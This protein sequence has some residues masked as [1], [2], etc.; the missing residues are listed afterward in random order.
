MQHMFH[1]IDNFAQFN[2]DAFGDGKYAYSGRVS[3]LPWYEDNGRD[4]LHLAVAYQWRKGSQPQD[5]NGGTTLP[6]NPNPAITTN[7]D[8]VR[9]RTRPGLRDAT[10]LQG[11]GTRVIDTGNIIA[12]HVQ[13]VNGEF[14]LYRGPFWVQSETNYSQVDNAFYPASNAATSRGT[15]NF[16]GTYVQTGFFLTGENRGY[17]KPMGKYGR[18]VPRTNF[19]LTRDESGCIRS[20]PGAWELTYRY[21]YVDLNIKTIQGG[22]YGEHTIG[23][24]WYWNSNIKIQFNYI[25]GA[26]TVP[27]G[28]TSGTVQ[29]FG[30]RGSLE[31]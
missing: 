12:D 29:G 7:T 8:L 22:L 31:F 24:N 17:D 18:V 28:T 5:F 25:N 6:S 16:W 9:F 20:G 4:L 30:M 1:R 15:L 26:R 19:F 14:L 13:S 3:V 21:G 2:G 11:D 27:A 23:L 10:A